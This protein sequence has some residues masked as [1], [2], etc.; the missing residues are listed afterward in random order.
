MRNLGERER[1]RDGY[2]LLITFLES[3]DMGHRHKAKMC[4]CIYA[5]FFFPFGGE[6][7]AYTSVGF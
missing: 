3:L 2:E 5:F 1:E 6:I 7:S 4:A